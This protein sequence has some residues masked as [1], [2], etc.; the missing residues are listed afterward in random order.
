MDENVIDEKC[1]NKENEKG[2]L[3]ENI[4]NIFA[5]GP[6]KNMHILVKNSEC[7]KTGIFYL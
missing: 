2:A 1:T 7:A 6:C 4:L 3:N 5:S